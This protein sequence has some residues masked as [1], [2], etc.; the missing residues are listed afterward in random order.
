MIKLFYQGPINLVATGNL[1]N[2]L[3]SSSNAQATENIKKKTQTNQKNTSKKQT[4]PKFPKLI[5][6]YKIF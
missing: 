5:N 3:H 2:N 6:I 4:K 1:K